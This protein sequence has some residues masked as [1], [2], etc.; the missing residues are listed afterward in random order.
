MTDDDA[1]ASYRE[2][3]ERLGRTRVRIEVGRAH[4]VFG[5]WL[6]RQNRRLQAREQLRN[7]HEMLSAIGPVAFAE[8]AERGSGP[9]ARP[10]ACE[11][12]RPATS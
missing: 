12:P 10:P 6:R 2:A 5:E 9:P 4:L 7:A 3:I 8:R 1:E 11:P